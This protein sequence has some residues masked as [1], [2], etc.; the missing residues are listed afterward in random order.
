MEKKELINRAKRLKKEMEKYVQKPKAT[1]KDLVILL[2]CVE[3]EDYSEVRKTKLYNK[4][5]VEYC[6]YLEIIA[7]EV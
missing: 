2:Q 3:K 1:Y 4:H 5:S 7:M 6:E